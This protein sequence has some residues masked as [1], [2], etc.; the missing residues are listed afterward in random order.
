MT[1][2]FRSY[3][4]LKVWQLGMDIAKGVYH[5]TRSF[6]R[7]ELFTYTSQMRRS[8]LSI[9]SNIAEGH[10]RKS[11]KE[12]LH[13]LSI[14]LGSVAE[15]ETQLELAAEIGLA[16]RKAIQ[17]ILFQLEELGRMIRG[18]TKSLKTSL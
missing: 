8:S 11:T 4:D 15:L 16:K 14:N 2:T 13:F 10:A 1:N 6:P 5:L 18:L 3:R 12:F 9:P 7:E 17:N